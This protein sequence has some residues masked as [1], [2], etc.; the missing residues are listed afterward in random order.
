M[1]IFYSLLLIGATA[2]WGSTFLITKTTI[3]N[4]DP[5]LIVI[6]RFIIAL[7][8]IL[9][10]T[11]LTRKLDLKKNFKL[12]YL[13][14]IF[15]GIVFISQNIGLQYTSSANSGFITASFIIYVPI[16]NF[17]IIKL[18]PNLFEFL[19]IGIA[20]IGIWLLTGGVSNL[21]IGDLITFI[22]SISFAMYVVSSQFALKNNSPINLTT[23][24]FISVIILGLLTIPF[25]QN[26][27]SSEQFQKALPSL[28]YLGIFASCI[29]YFIQVL[30]QSK[31]NS[32]TTSLI[33]SVEPIFV[34]IFGVLFDNV[35]FTFI[36]IVGAGLLILGIIMTDID[37]M[38]IFSRLKTKKLQ[39]D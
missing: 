31:L 36:E 27:P 9:T 23:Q 39:K 29:A 25:V 5:L 21:N 14:G 16:I 13:S 10:T 12:S 15:L 33:L 20:L 38:K 18:K 11:I 7:P 3:E 30:V 35:T 8:I 37:L 19:S 34:A 28:I 4:V 17:L 24:Q 26:W 1:K 2:I 22:S 6:V 32:I